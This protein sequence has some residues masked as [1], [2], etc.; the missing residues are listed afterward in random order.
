MQADGRLLAEHTNQQKEIEAVF[1]DKLTLA[2]NKIAEL[3]DE[4]VAVEKKY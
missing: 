2:T 3:K 4:K 1:T